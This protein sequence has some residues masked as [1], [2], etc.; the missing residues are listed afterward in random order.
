M[1]AVASSKVCG[2]DTKACGTLSSYFGVLRD[3]KDMRKQWK[4][5]DEAARLLEAN[6]SRWIEMY[7]YDTVDPKYTLPTVGTVKDVFA[8]KKYKPVAQK[9]RPIIGGLP[10]EFRIVHEIKGDPLKDMPQLS[11]HPLEYMP[12]GRYTTECKEIIERV[13]KEDF[14]WP[15]EHKL[16]HE[17]MSVQNEG[18]AWDDM[19]CGHFKEEYFPPVMIPAVEHTP[20]IQKNIPIPPGIFDQVC[21]IIK[22]KID[23][24]VYEPSN[25][26]Y[27]S[28]WFCVVKKDGKSL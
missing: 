7:F 15:E 11:T 22:T 5:A 19:E 14:L 9:I 3:I 21:K 12:M 27:C 26:S 16:M 6:P 2:E 17:F 23:A 1:Y 13:H 8:M 28:C 10:S 24:G 20:W 18:F 25:S 4:G